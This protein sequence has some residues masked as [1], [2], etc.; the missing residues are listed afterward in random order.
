MRTQIYAFIAELAGVDIDELRPTTPVE[1]LGISS[2]DW[3]EFVWFMEDE[4]GIK[5]DTEKI[6][7]LL[8][9]NLGSFTDYFV[10]VPQAAIQKGA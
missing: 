2:L 6:R 3:V 10:C 8:S 5:T 7:P 9:G 4:F 1:S